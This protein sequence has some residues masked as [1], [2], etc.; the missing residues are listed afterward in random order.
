MITVGMKSKFFLLESAKEDGINP[1]NYRSEEKVDEKEEYHNNDKL[2]KYHSQKNKRNQKKS[3]AQELLIQKIIDENGSIDNHVNDDLP[4]TVRD[5]VFRK[6]VGLLRVKFKKTLRVCKT[7]AERESVNLQDIEVGFQQLEDMVYQC[8]CGWSRKKVKHIVQGCNNEDCDKCGHDKA[9]DSKGWK[10][11]FIQTKYEDGEVKD[12]DRK[13]THPKKSRTLE[14]QMRDKHENTSYKTAVYIPDEKQ[15]FVVDDFQDLITR[16]FF[17]GAIKTRTSQVRRDNIGRIDADNLEN[18]DKD[19]LIYFES[20]NMEGSDFTGKEVRD[21]AKYAMVLDYYYDG[22]Y[23]LQHVYNGQITES[24]EE[25]VETYREKGYNIRNPLHIDKLV[26][27]F[28]VD[29]GAI[30][31]D[32][33]RTDD[34]REFFFLDKSTKEKWY[35]QNEIV[36]DLFQLADIDDKVWQHAKESLLKVEDED[37]FTVKFERIKQLLPWDH[38]KLTRYLLDYLNFDSEENDFRSD[39]LYKAVEDLQVNE[40]TRKEFLKQ[41]SGDYDKLADN[42]QNTQEVLR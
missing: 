9:W 18:S 7:L 16:L 26:D 19:R 36:C 14:V 8:D 21:T 27:I 4:N 5:I 30:I 17:A 1:D 38:P 3:K 13:V 28:D 6:D 42:Y 24:A 34:S 39:Y 32:P 33:K 40:R 41:I 31:Y 2:S 12:L 20:K 29:V 23:A 11:E 37:G 35:V 25:A 10:N 22:H 15:F